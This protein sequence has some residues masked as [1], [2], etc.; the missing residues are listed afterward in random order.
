MRVSEYRTVFSNPFLQRLNLVVS[1][2]LVDPSSD[3]LQ[4][5]AGFV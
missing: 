4:F 3:L 1:R 5:N 2:Q